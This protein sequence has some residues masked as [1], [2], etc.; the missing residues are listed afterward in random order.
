MFDAAF[1]STMQTKQESAMQISSAANTGAIPPPGEDSLLKAH[2][3]SQAFGVAATDDPDFSSLTHTQLRHALDENRLLLDHALPAM[4]TLYGQIANTGNVVVLSSAQ[5][6]LLRTLGDADFEEKASKVA[7]L[8]G[9]DWSERT[10]G[11]NAVGTALSEQQPVTVHGKQHFLIA[12]KILACSCAPI[13]DP[14]GELLGALDVTGDH[15]SHHQHTLALVRMSVQM[16]ENRML[17]NSF[18]KAIQLHFHAGAEFLGTLAE[19][20]VA[21][22]RDG[23]FLSANRSAQFQLGMSLNALKAHTFSSLFDLPISALFELFGNAPASPRQ[24][25]MHNGVTVWCVADI[26]PTGPWIAPL[27]SASQEVNP[28]RTATQVQK[29]TSAV[30]GATARSRSS[31]RRSASTLDSLD[32]GDRQV[33]SVIQKL[34]KVANHDIP[35]LILGET[36]TGKDLMAR[37]IHDDSQRAHKPFVPVNCASIPDTL[38]EA[39][40]FGYEEGAFTGAR[41]KGSPGKILQAH[42]GTLFLDEI[43]DMPPHLQARLLRVL[44]E[45]RVSPLGS[46][47]ELNVDIYVVSATHKNLKEMIARGQF[48]EDLYYRLNGMVVQLP[49]LRDRSDF[50]ALVHKIL[51]SLSKS[52]PAVAISREVMALLRR[53]QWP[54]NLR[55]LHNLLRTAV[56][57]ASDD[58]C[59]E[60]EHLPDDFLMEVADAGTPLVA[61]DLLDTPS[62]CVAAA[63]SELPPQPDT[64]NQRLQ[65]V[66]LQT[67]VQI[68]RQHKG[69]IS[70][71]AKALGVSRNTIYRKKH[72]LPE[73]LID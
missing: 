26:R 23:R 18:P 69:N 50:E 63:P 67:M 42:G 37:A 24:L 70:A 12:N 66:T 20:V 11:T 15:R 58:G 25:C 8:P 54:G 47:S 62:P 21:F 31:S 29:A 35:V 46:V 1:R 64:E 44:Q 10:K 34:R 28:T 41:K 72:L 73:G 16:M 57:M 5:G 30:E 45:R 17:E 68:L 61:T 6:V 33:H 51:Q 43:G 48:R 22:T 36:G 14:E 59:I 52:G 19:G 71:A 4:Q 32:T 49:A 53:H 38:I 9:V 56:V 55:Q 7:L 3:R 39:E 27:F 60:P 40:L 65:D 13:F 2:E